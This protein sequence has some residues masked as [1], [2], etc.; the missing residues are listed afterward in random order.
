[1][2]YCKVFI[3]IGIFFISLSFDVYGQQKDDATIEGIYI[4]KGTSSGLKVDKLSDG[5]YLFKLILLRS[6]GEIVPFEG[7]SAYVMPTHNLTYIFYWHT[8]RYEDIP[9]TNDL[10]VYNLV[11]DGFQLKGISFFP[12]KPGIKPREIIFIKR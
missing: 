9:G 12:E 8:G 2:R 3:V 10:I 11:F 1:M 4:Q 6:N 5:N 7:Q